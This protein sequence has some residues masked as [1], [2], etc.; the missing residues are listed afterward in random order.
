MA[1]ASGPGN[2]R[3]NDIAASVHRRGSWAHVCEYGANGWRLDGTEIVLY[4][5]PLDYS[6]PLQGAWVA[7]G[8]G[9]DHEVI[10][11][12]LGVSMRYVEENHVAAA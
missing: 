3:N 10:D 1:N 9:Y 5:D 12:Y 11:H 2:G 6:G 7:V 4:Y 8:G